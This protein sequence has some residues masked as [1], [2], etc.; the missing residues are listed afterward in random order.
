MSCTSFCRSWERRRWRCSRKKEWM[1]LGFRFKGGGGGGRR[2]IVGC[3]IVDVP[4][5]GGSESEW[6]GLKYR[7]CDCKLW[8]SSMIQTLITSQMRVNAPW[9]D[10]AKFSSSPLWHSLI[11]FDVF[12]SSQIVFK[13]HSRFWPNCYSFIHFVIPFHDCWCI[14]FL[15]RFST[16][17]S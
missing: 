5:S 2:K 16:T 4:H 12:I 9:V 1:R 13:I 11:V 6:N 7:F 15:L 17:V 8:R 3:V 10:K 14:S